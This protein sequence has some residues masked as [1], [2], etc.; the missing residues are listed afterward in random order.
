MKY[1]KILRKFLESNL[2]RK[3][4]IFLP[5]L[6]LVFS[7][8]PIFGGKSLAGHVGFDLF[9]AS[10]NGYVEYEIKGNPGQRLASFDALAPE[11]AG[12][13][14]KYPEVRFYEIITKDTKNSSQVGVSVKVTLKKIQERKADK[15]RSVFEVDKLLLQDFESIR[16]EGYEVASKV[17]EGGPPAAKAIGLK[18]TTTSTKDLDILI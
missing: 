4:S 3:L 13:I 14:S 18:L 2:S 6:L 5:V 17:Q 7:F 8:V 16:R 1:K 15:L 9:P 12:I 11:V 10:D